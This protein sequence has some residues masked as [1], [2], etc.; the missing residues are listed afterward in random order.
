MMPKHIKV[1]ERRVVVSGNVITS[2]GPGTAI[3]FALAL[4]QRLFGEAKRLEVGGPMLV[5]NL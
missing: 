3:E 2:R 4:V 5:A 1:D